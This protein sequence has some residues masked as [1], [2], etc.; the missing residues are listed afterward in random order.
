MILDSLKHFGTCFSLIQAL[1][2]YVR[3]IILFLE[4]SFNNP[5]DIPSIPGDFLGLI[6]FQLKLQE[7]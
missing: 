5:G 4:S 7:E 3:N 2:I 6:L 1:N